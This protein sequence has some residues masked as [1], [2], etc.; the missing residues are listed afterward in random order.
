M[1]QLQGRIFKGDEKTVIQY[2]LNLNLLNVSQFK[3]VYVAEKDLDGKIYK[4]CENIRC[5]KP[6]IFHCII[7]Q[8]I[9]C[10][11]CFNLSFVSESIMSMRT[12]VLSHGPKLL[13]QGPALWCSK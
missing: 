12:F 2:N 13:I 9:P 10:G 4:V 3:N 11:E 1:K 7:H 8:Y 6:K 5:L